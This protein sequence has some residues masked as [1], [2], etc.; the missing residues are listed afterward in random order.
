[1]PDYNTASLGATRNALIELAKH[2]GSFDHAF[3]AKRIST[4]F[5]TWSQPQPDGE[6]FPIGT[7]PS[8][9]ARRLEDAP[10]H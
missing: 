9:G 2:L 7:R 10:N 8:G 4:R 3:G 5:V 6:V 1:M